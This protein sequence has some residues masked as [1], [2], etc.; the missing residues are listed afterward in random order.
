[1]TTPVIKYWN[2]GLL[3][4]VL[5][6]APLASAA[7]KPAAVDPSIAELAVLDSD[8]ARF[9]R[10]L[11]QYDDPKYKG[12]TQEIYDVLKERTDGVHKAFDQLKCDDLRWDI[13]MQS[14]R[15]ARAMAPLDTPPPSSKNQVDLEELAPNPANQAEV[16]AALNALDDA[17]ARKEAQA[18]ALTAGREAAAAR[19]E[20]LKKARSALTSKFTTEGWTTAVKELKKD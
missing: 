7:E 13:N 14:Q 4:A 2:L 12:Y 10:F 18:K 17:I 11:K 19:V 9:E 6:A 16:T 1:M 8:L 5:G 15:L 3:L 20:G